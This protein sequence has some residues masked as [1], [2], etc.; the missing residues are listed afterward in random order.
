VSAPPWLAQRF[1]I[2]ALA[3]ASVFLLP[4]LGAGLLARA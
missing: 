4:A 2:A 1:A 3:V